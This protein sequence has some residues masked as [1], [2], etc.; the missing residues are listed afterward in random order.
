M[1]RTNPGEKRTSDTKLDS[2]STKKFGM[3]NTVK[4]RE[5][6]GDKKGGRIRRS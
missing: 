2:K 1:V 6:K 4:S 3:R 5:I